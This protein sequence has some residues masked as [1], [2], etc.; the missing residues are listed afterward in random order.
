MAGF[1]E[2]IILENSFPLSFICFMTGMFWLDEILYTIFHL[3]PLFVV[4]YIREKR[5]Q[6]LILW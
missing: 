4:F 2:S 3:Q 1:V 6:Y 5:F